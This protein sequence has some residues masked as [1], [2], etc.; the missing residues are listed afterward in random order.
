MRYNL[1]ETT[2]SGDIKI[3]DSNSSTLII[4]KSLT[5]VDQSKIKFAFSKK[6]EKEQQDLLNE[7]FE[8]YSTYKEPMR[9]IK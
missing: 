4:F 2:F 6:N 8:K 7:F 5:D 9:K 1:L 3:L